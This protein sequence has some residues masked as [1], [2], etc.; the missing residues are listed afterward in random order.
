MLENLWKQ[1][2]DTSL[3]GLISKQWSEIGFQGDDPSTDFRG[4]GLLGLENLLFFSTHYNES[5]RHLLQHS[6]HPV[7]G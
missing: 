2:M 5:A 7:H 4:M 3:T 6:L 1:L